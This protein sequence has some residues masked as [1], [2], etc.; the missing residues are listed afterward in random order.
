M[1]IQKIKIENFK[2]FGE[3]Q[4]FNLKRGI[5]A[6]V[7]DNGSGKTTVLEAIHKVFGGDKISKGDFH[8]SKKNDD[9][10][11]GSN[12]ISIDIM[13]HIN[14]NEITPYVQ[15]LLFKMEDEM[16]V[17]IRLEAESTLNEDYDD[18]E[19]KTYVVYTKRDVEFGKDAVS[20][21]KRPITQRELRNFLEYIYIPAHR[22]GKA[23]IAEK[24]KKILKKIENDIDWGNTIQV[25]LT[26]SAKKLQEDFE[27][28]SPITYIKNSLTENYRDLYDLAHGNNPK[29]A[30]SQ[31][32]FHEIIR[33]INL[34]FDSPFSTN[35]LS[36][37]D[38]SEGQVSLLYLA[39]T[40]THHNLIYKL[41]KGETFSGSEKFKDKN[42][43]SPALILFGLEEPENH[44]SPFYL[45]KIMC[46]FDGL[47]DE[48][49]SQ[50]IVTSHSTSILRHIP[51]DQ[52]SFLRRDLE[53]GFC[54][55][56]EINLNGIADEDT[57]FIKQAVENN[58][59]IYFARLMI[60]GEGDSEKVVISKIAKARKLDLDTS[61]V[62]FVSIGG[63]H[64]NH[65]WRLADMLDIPCITLLDYDK[66]RHRGG[67]QRITD[68]EK[69]LNDIDITP[70]PDGTVGDEIWRKYEKSHAIYYSYPIDLDMLMIQN[71][72]DV[73][74][75]GSTVSYRSLLKSVYKD[76]A[77]KGLSPDVSA[78]DVPHFPVVAEEQLKAY[79]ALFDSKSKVVSHEHALDGLENKTIGRGCPP[80]LERLIE[81]AR[82][83]L[84]PP[85]PNPVQ[86][87]EANDISE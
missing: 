67:K 41:S 79:K 48:M 40:I 26:K 28:F 56:R 17:R 81:D 78:S 84:N 85:L 54:F 38:L 51:Y 59:E 63:R 76:S 12:R 82:Y 72:P 20:S 37:E 62:A 15:P 42:H 64:A 52:V 75:G 2:C 44:L 69:W 18:V 39:L 25:N 50:T 27:N 35:S 73:Y 34:F 70:N 11:D 36:L 45:S 68:A 13:L 16:V 8:K 46:K 83:K 47:K 19:C 24:L 32:E 4:S 31:I 57:K 60:I 22:D 14:E 61:F 49:R 10:G 9:A 5:N 7:G 55:S 3:E 53:N 30:I 58:P 29:L 6:L 71:F 80:V 74:R 66:G 87:S 77:V 23:V 1:Y 21:D 43:Y 33:S 86:E 65:L